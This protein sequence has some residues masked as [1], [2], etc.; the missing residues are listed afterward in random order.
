MPGAILESASTIV[1]RLLTLR[2]QLSSRTILKLLHTNKLPEEFSFEQLIKQSLRWTSYYRS[3]GL[4]PGEKVVVVLPHSSTLYFSY[5]GAVLGGFIPAMFSFPSEK[6]SK[7]RYFKDVQQLIEQSEARLIVCY[8]EIAAELK[9]LTSAAIATADSVN[10]KGACDDS[11]ETAVLPN[12]MAFLQYSSGTTGIKKGVAI[13]HEMLLWQIEQYATAIGLT[14]E[15]V[16]VSWLPLY[17]D[18]GL[19]SSF[20]LPLLAG[21]PLVALSAFDWVKRPATLLEAITQNQASLCWQPNFAYNHLA[22]SVS[23]SEKK[24]LDLSSMRLFVNCSEPIMQS[25]HQLF[26]DAFSTCGLADNALGS[27]YA[28]AENTFAVTSAGGPSPLCQEVIDSNRLSRENRAWRAP[29]GLPGANVLVSSG[30]A[31]ADTEISIRNAAGE[32]VADREIGEIWVRSPCLMKGYHNNIEATA[33]AFEDGCY[34]SGDLGFMIEGELFV[35]GRK[36][37]LLIIAGKNVYP[38]D[39]EALLSTTEGVIPGR[40]VALGIPDTATGTELLVIVA[41]TAEE[42]EEARKGICLAVHNVIAKNTEIKAHDVCLVPHKTLEKSSSGKMARAANLKLYQKRIR[43]PALKIQEAEGVEAGVRRALAKVVQREDVLTRELGLITSGVIDSLDFVALV[44]ALEEEFSIKVPSNLQLNIDR[45]NTITDIIELVEEVQNKPAPL[46]NRWWQKENTSL[47]DRKCLNFLN[48][49]KDFDMLF[50]GSSRVF[51]LSTSLAKRFGYKAYNF[52]VNNAQ[53]EDCYSIFAFVLENNTTALRHLVFGVD[54]DAFNNQFSPTGFLL[55]SPF[56][57]PYLDKNDDSLLGAFYREENPMEKRLESIAPEKHKQFKSMA[58][59][60]RT[61]ALGKKD[62]DDD[63]RFEYDAQTGEMIWAAG[64]ENAEL[65]NSRE[66]FANQNPRVY[67][68]REKEKMK[69]FSA[70]LPKRVE[71]FCRLID[72]CLQNNIQVTCFLTAIH[73]NLKNFLLGST[74]FSKRLYDLHLLLEARY[75]YLGPDKLQFHDLSSPESFAGVNEDFWDPE[76]MG[77]HNADLLL[78]YL[79]QQS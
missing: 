18:M 11:I 3:I 43:N 30:Q 14:K 20:W 33:E 40:A 79:L 64:Y 74:T 73:P 1:D 63:G 41:E 12:S 48:G 6:F 16:V 24:Y 72:T 7:E 29:Y 17:H 5:V 70:L 22:R 56:L 47:R 55:R 25:S 46:E 69:N 54:I 66:P 2:R 52:S 67:R 13:S 42:N 58:L 26:I 4:Q 77:A 60:L 75:G 78:T 45:F 36:K 49:S 34:K 65:F 27:S 37:D 8:E 31:L 28:M 19:I 53:I 39:I 44:L 62:D 23:E 76:H 50:L 68:I 51:S 35:T 32:V 59:R 61:Q 15:D 10:F 57:M 21:I 38:Q 71:Y 9:A